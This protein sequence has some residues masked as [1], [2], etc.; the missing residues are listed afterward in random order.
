MPGKKTYKELEHKYRKLKE[1]VRELKKVEKALL[2]SERKLSTLM[3][4]LPGMAYRCASDD[5]WTILFASRGTFSLLGYQAEDLVGD[6]I[7]TF[8]E[9]VHPEDRP[10][11][12][13]NIE[14]ALAAKTSYQLIYRIKTVSGQDNWKWVWD[15][16]EGIFSSEG[17][18]IALEG[19]ITDISI[20]KL[21]EMKLQEEN[22]LLRSSIKERF[23]FG[24]IIGKSP[25]MQKVYDLI[26][27]AAAGC[28]NVIIYGESGTGK[29]L[30]ARA[31]HDHSDRKKNA[32][33]PVN[34]GAIPENLMESEFF[35]HIKGAF[36]SAYSDKKGYLDSA[37][38]GTLFLDELGE[39]SLN[40]QVKLLRVLDGMG[41]MP[42]GSNIVKNPDVR[43]IAATNRDIKSLM[44]QG[45]IR[46]DFYY[47]IH[48][49]PIALPLLKERKGDIPLL[50]DHFLMQHHIEEN[51]NFF[52]FKLRIAFENY[53]WPGNIRELKNIVERYVTLG[54][55]GFLNRMMT[56]NSDDP[57]P[58]PEPPDNKPPDFRNAVEGF[59]KNFILKTLDQCQWR[60]GKAASLMGI[61]A[62]TLQRKL[63]R[64]Q[65]K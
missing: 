56:R 5:N 41:Y 43:I 25:E 44:A 18:L 29:E 65:I 24:D 26:L 35:G 53:D 2:E 30:V 10:N 38:K 33:V 19:F 52:P 31:I 58:W 8:R 64:Y 36:S 16:G 42:V 57:V 22:L 50:V 61:T 1:Q 54:E 11:N 47:R 21:K 37:D 27:K 40:L 55:T 34:C 20:H 45:K 7:H 12:L 62:R 23:R 48:I 28:A 4:N 63:K 13:I 49:L 6:P 17:T 51:H 32:F 3:N 15:Q 9:L 39:I 60:K 14:K 59:E 46:K